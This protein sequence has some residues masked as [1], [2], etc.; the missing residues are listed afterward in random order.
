MLEQIATILLGVLATPLLLA[1]GIV[2][3]WA[4]FYVVVIVAHLVMGIFSTDEI[5]ED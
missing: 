3:I 5:D 4:M 1:F 2:L